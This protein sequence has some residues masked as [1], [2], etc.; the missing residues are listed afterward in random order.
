M[1]KQYLEIGK[2]VSV[3]GIKG[4]VRVNPWSDSPDFLLEFDEFYYENGTEKIII[5]NSRVQKNVV[6]LK[7]E[8]IDTVEEAQKL[9][10]K[11][12]Y[13]NREDIELDDG[14][15]FIQDLIGV[16]VINKDD[17]SI[18]YGDIVDVSQTGANDVYHIK[19]NN[20]Q[21]FYI[22]AIPQVIISTDIDNGIM[23]I[24]PLRGLFDDED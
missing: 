15:Y 23:E 7:I 5:L 21:I 24:R 3:K 13:I 2:I 1:K 11:I 9:R 4:E 16:K 20:G 12:L 19:A 18:I 22:P 8:G 17:N 10:N 14:V 6:I